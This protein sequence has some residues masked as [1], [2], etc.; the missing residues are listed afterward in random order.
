MK[1]AQEIQFWSLHWEDPLEKEKQPTPVFWPEKSF[2]QRSLA[3]YSP[4]GHKESD[5][6]GQLS[7]HKHK[8]LKDD[9][10]KNITES[11]K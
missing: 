9:S 2:G 6:T 5:T 7:M 3:G 4:K 8:S 11:R 1:E 10:F